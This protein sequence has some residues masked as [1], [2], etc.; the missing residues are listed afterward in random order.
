MIKEKSFSAYIIPIRNVGGCTQFAFLKYGENGYGPIGGR[1]DDGEDL[2]QALKRELVEELGDSALF[3]ADIA[4][5][6]DK[7]YCFIHSPERAIKRGA[8]SEE[9]NYFI[10]SIPFDTELQFCENRPDK[11]ELTWLSVEQLI[12]PNII[13]FTDLCEYFKE[14]IIML[15]KIIG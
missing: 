7:P 11:I 12:N 1:V 2:L 3:M 9:H 13:G 14:N 6:I 8:K 4:K 5:K 15:L 10:A